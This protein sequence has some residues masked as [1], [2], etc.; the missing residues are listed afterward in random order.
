MT[1]VDRAKAFKSLIEEFQLT[2]Q[3]IAGKVG[4][5]REYVSNSIRLLS[6]EDEMIDALQR[7]IIS[8]GHARPLLMLS[9]R[10]EQRF[11]DEIMNSI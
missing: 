9:D 6:L 1:P 11:L 8:E 7:G 4:K 5:S 3:N 10:D 2:H